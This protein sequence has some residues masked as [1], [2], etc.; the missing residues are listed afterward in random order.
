MKNH[1][2]THSFTQMAELLHGAS[3]LRGPSSKSS[4][5]WDDPPS[6]LS[7]HLP[8]TLRVVFSW[9]MVCFHSA[10]RRCGIFLGQGMN[11]SQPGRRRKVEL[12]SKSWKFPGNS[13]NSLGNSWENIG[14]VNFY[15]KLSCI[16][17]GKKKEPLA[18]SP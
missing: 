17:H 15:G 11:H 8:R 16:N 12:E 13:Y 2:P 1:L 3:Y 6:E 5:S 10:L 7:A 18:V 14:I 9:P 4:K